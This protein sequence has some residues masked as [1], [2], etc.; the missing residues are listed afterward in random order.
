MSVIDKI[1]LDGTTY[2]VGKTPDTTL[3]VSGSPA[4]AAKVGTELDKKVDKVTGKGLSTEDFTTAEKTKL[5]GIAEGATA[6]TIDATLTQSG[7]AADAKVV[8]KIKD[9][10]ITE[11][12]SEVAEDVLPGLTFTEGKYMATTG[13]ISSA[14]TLKYSSK[15]PVTEGDVIELTGNT[16]IRFLCAFNGDTAVSAKGSQNIITYTVPEGITDI[17]VTLYIAQPG[18]AL[19]RIQSVKT[20]KNIY[21]DEIDGFTGLLRKEIIDTFQWMAGYFSSTQLTY[22]GQGSYNLL[23]FRC[24]PNTTYTITKAI[25]TPEFKVCYIKTIPKANLSQ[26]VYNYQVFPKTAEEIAYTTGDDALFL[27]IMIGAAADIPDV[28]AVT[29]SAKAVSTQFVVADETARGMLGYINAYLPRTLYLVA[30]RAYEIYHN[31][32]CPKADGYTFT[33]T[34]GTNYGNRVRFLFSSTTTVN[35]MCEIRTADGVV[36]K[37]MRTKIVVVPPTSKTVSLLPFG[38]SLTNHCVW[39][40]EL[41]NIAPSVTCVGSRSRPV[42]D[43]D[44]EVRTVYN[45]GRAGFTALNYLNGRDYTGV[46]DSGGDETGHNRWYDPDQNAFSAQ[47]YFENHFPSDQTAPNMMTVFLGMND[48]MGVSTESKIVADIRSIIDNIRTHK[49]DMPIAVISPQLQYI[50]TLSSATQIRFINFAK[51]LEIAVTENYT[52]VAFVPLLVGMDSV[53]GYPQTTVTVNTRSTE[54]EKYITDI[55][56]PGKIGYWQI[57]DYIFGA[58]S[59]LAQ[60]L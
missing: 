19:N 35:V 45:E 25:Q 58:V 42:A 49:P 6:L 43:S 15:I 48:L 53:N 3:A 12:T 47:Y 14:N 9:V 23:Y 16:S 22:W 46:S 20:Y 38:D 34:H 56:H 29:A 50:P 28:Y 13:A 2:D 24:K 37:A 52:N 32:I 54:T 44:D 1:K 40:S 8:G 55:T 27:L 31:Q 4:D 18:T 5:A 10:V 59:Y 26:P 11:E 57:A 21:K 17:V 41:M 30:G 33:W 39:E 36:V 60:S 7:Q 51:A